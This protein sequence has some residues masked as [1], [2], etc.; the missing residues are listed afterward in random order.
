MRLE[1]ITKFISK[2]L[3]PVYDKPVFEFGLNLLES[4]NSI[5]EIVILTNKDNDAAIRKSGHRTIIQDDSKVSDMFS[6][7]N[8]IKKATGTKKNAVLYP[9]DNIIQTSIDKLVKTFADSNAD[10]LFL[11]KKINDTVKLSQ[12]GSFDIKM[13]K[14][15]YKKSALKNHYAVIA[16]YIISN[17]K[18]AGKPESFFESSRSVRV[19]YKGKWFDIGDYGSI[20]DAGKW[21][22]REAEKRK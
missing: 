14:Y 17:E 13:G 9:G 4:S 6:G 22:R 12:M 7:W 10:F 15:F 20:V 19:I 8:F 1:K 18:T 21:R 2:P 5:D 11:L 16:P 3:I